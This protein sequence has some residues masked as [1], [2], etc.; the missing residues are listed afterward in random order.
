MMPI[1]SAPWNPKSIIGVKKEKGAGN[2]AEGKFAHLLQ[3][4]KIEPLCLNYMQFLTYI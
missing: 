1:S 3:G 4:V 2:G